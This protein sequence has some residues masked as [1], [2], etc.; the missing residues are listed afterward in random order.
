MVYPKFR[1]LVMST[2]IMGVL[3][4]GMIMIAPAP[5]IGEVAKYLGVDLGVTTFTVMALWTVSVCIG[6]IVGGAVVDKVGVVKIY[7]VC[8]VLLILSAALTPAVGP[9]LNG[10]IVLRLLGGLG[11]GPILTTIARTAAE[12]FPRKERGLITGVQGMAVAL[13][14]FAG[15]GASP[16]VFSKL[17]S[18]PL[19]MACMAVPAIIFLLLSAVLLLGPKAPELLVEEHEDARAASED[20]RTALKEPA[21]YLCVVCIF[22]FNWLLQGVNDLTPGYF[23]IGPPVGIGWGPMVAGK[24]MM[25]FQ[26]AFMLG[27]LVSGWINDKI[28]RG[29]Y[30]LQIM[31][32]FIIPGAYCFIRL[33]SVLAAGPNSILLGIIIV[34]AFSM[35]QGIA[36]VMAFISKNYPE[37]ITGKVGGIA[38]G[39]GL[40]GGTVGVGCGSVALTKTCNYH[41]SILIV[42]AIAFIGFFCAMALRRP[43]A[44]SQLMQAQ[45]SRSSLP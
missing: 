18:W 40:I 7:L 16:A 2:M 28:Y 29:S 38:M 3:A 41:V 10:I 31:L 5:L 45:E 20:F 12:W 19:T 13:G 33:P 22:L 44:F 39:L 37:H 26:F 23:A 36:T 32:A 35:G 42:T 9:V 4:Q 24:L 34:T 21:I 1:W 8:A 43:K 17:H 27:A 25:I 15:F 14:V 11:T 6:G 30:K